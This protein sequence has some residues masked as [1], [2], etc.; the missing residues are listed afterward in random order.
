MKERHDTS[1]DSSQTKQPSRNNN[2]NN[3]SN[4]K[5]N[6][7]RSDKESF[8]PHKILKKHRQ[9]M[10]TAE[11]KR[12]KQSLVR[13]KRR[14]KMPF[15][16]FTWIRTR[17]LCSQIEGYASKQKATLLTKEQWKQAL[18]L[19]KTELGKITAEWKKNQSNT[20]TRQ[21]RKRKRAKRRNPCPT[22]GSDGSK[23]RAG[24]CGKVFQTNVWTRERNELDEQCRKAANCPLPPDTTVPSAAA[25]KDS[26]P[27]AQLR[28]RLP[29]T[30]PNPAL[31]AACS[32]LRYD[33]EIPDIS[34]SNSCNGELPSTDEREC[35]GSQPQTREHSVFTV[36][37]GVVVSLAVLVS[38][39]VTRE[40]CRF[41]TK[42]VPNEH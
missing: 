16:H 27:T 34:S 9:L 33:D 10:D 28:V 29:D 17:L 31:A 3:N 6:N 15:V 40:Q 5:N 14:R 24:G 25:I 42:W 18:A 11:A 21:H 20:K 12:T 23:D 30:E 8:L 4:N 2:S 13:N 35:S 26:H 19:A 37:N 32:K 36:R 39:L 38:V 1:N 41:P 22:T 7:K